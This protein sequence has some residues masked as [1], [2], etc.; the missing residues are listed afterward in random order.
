[1]GAEEARKRHRV[2]FK[3]KVESNTPTMMIMSLFIAR[4]DN[5]DSDDVD[6]N[7]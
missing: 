6:D 2:G 7:R 1:L 3:L 5:D 4:A